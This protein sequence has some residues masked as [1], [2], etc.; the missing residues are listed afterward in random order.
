MSQQEVQDRLDGDPDQRKPSDPTGTEYVVEYYELEEE[1]LRV[2]GV[3]GVIV[4]HDVQELPS[5][6]D[7]DDD[8]RDDGEELEIHH[9]DVGQ[10][11]STL[12]VTPSNETILI[13]TGD[14]YQDGDEYADGQVVID[15][16][17][18]EG[19]DKIDR[20]VATHPDADHIGGH[21]DVIEH[22][23][24]ERNGVNAAIDPGLD[25]ETSTSQN[26]LEALDEHNVDRFSVEEGDSLQLQ[27]ELIE[28]NILNP[29]S[30][31]Y[32]K[33][34]HYNSIAIV[35]EYNNFRYLSSGDAERAAEKRMVENW[36]TQLGAS[37]YHAGHHG[38][39]TSST[40]VFLQAV[41]PDI[42]VVS[43]AKESPF[44]HPDDSVLTRLSS[45]DVETYWTGVHG[46]ITMKINNEGKIDV[47]VKNEASTDPLDLIHKKNE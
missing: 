39:S 23:E 7:D 4:S 20:L 10:A 18:A 45:Y 2:I 36:E 41:E 22:F 31:N 13:D 16:L 37:V 46:D 30:E 38:S 25:P 17:E 44:G 47:D 24:T 21:A 1:V 43:S 42:A 34:R 28:T 15:Y 26:Y 32:D 27:D 8:D 3:E 29:P 12:I 11:D 9:I 33:D 14:R 5:R 35:V 6:E 19:I 40:E